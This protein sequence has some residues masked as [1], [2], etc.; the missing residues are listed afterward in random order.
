[1]AI[2]P[3]MNHILKDAPE[4]RA[5]NLATY[6]NPDLSLNNT[7]VEKMIRFIKGPSKN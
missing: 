6:N 5:E 3:G 4:D 1:L 7:L 2:I